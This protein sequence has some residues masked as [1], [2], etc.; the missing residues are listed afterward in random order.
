[1]NII[2]YA[3]AHILKA[4]RHWYYTV[5]GKGPRQQNSQSYGTEETHV[6]NSA[7]DRHPHRVII[8]PFAKTL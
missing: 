7:R 5:A 3:T 2:S 1:M 8:S 4:L 6:G